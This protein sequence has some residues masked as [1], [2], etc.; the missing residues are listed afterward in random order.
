MWL[1]IFFADNVVLILIWIY[2]EAI[3]YEEMYEF[4]LVACTLF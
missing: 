2:N 1:H 4:V 3:I